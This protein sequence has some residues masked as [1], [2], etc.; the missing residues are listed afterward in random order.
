M[1]RN[2]FILLIAI[3][4]LISCQLANDSQKNSLGLDIG[5]YYSEKKLSFFDPYEITYADGRFQGYTY[6]TWIRQP[7]NLKMVHETFKKIG[8]KK[9]FSKFNYSG[10]CGFIHDV[11]KPCD[12]LI[13]SLIL[14]YKTDTIESKYYREF[15]NRRINEKND[16]IV[17]EILKEVSY[18]VYLDSMILYDEKLINDTLLRL[19]EIRDFDDSLTIKKAKANF[20][21]L[22]RIGLHGSAYNLLYER[23]RY[24]DIEWNQEELKETLIIDTLK[25]F[26]Y[27]FIEDDTK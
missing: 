20:E 23:Y 9:L 15:W 11:R 24:Y 10:Y 21:Y 12:E 26:P 25:C 1:I 16:S 14:T 2:I 5:T 8:Y 6:E 13:D 22:K 19:I 7:E 4:G 27:A 3:I 18:D 17:F